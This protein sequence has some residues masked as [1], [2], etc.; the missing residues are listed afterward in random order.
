MKNNFYTS[1][2]A[3]KLLC[4]LLIMLNLAACKSDKNDDPLILPPNFSE[5]PDVKED[6]VTKKN[7]D[8]D[9][10]ENAEKN[11]SKNTD[12]ATSEDEKSKL[13]EED[14]KK[15]KELLLQGK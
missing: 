7:Q 3:G 8:S 6:S 9:K 11:D 1:I 4:G 2:K 15:L 10:S 5:L 14:N 12:K 13:N